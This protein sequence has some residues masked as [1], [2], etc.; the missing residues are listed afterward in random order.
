MKWLRFIFFV[1]Q[2]GSLNLMPVDFKARREAELKSLG[3]QGIEK[4]SIY[5][6]FRDKLLHNKPLGLFVE[7]I[8]FAKSRHRNKNIFFIDSLRL[9]YVRILKAGSTSL[10]REILPMMDDQLKTVAL[11]DGQVDQLANRYVEHTVKGAR[12]SYDFFTIV[13]NPFQRLVSVYLDLFGPEAYEFSHR[14]YLFGILKHGMSFAEFVKTLSVIPDQLKSP[15][16]LPQHQTIEACGGFGKV[17]WFRLENDKGTIEK[18][19]EPYKMN[20]GHSN[21]QK[22][23]Y[24]YRDFYNK[25][26][27]IV[28]YRIYKMDVEFFGYREEY[29]A[30][31]NYI[32]GRT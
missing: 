15:H 29:E 7:N 12:I 9:G 17:K 31:V 32:K 16:F 4:G 21:K 11:S 18:F 5:I 13:R 24:D 20:L 30:L 26:L 28:V 22:T 2:H 10:L 8:A 1:I 19:L 14:T 25:E 27:V 23:D 3:G 6:Q